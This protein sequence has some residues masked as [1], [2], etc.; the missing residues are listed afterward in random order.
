M[1]TFVKAAV[2]MQLA[3]D[4]V[5]RPHLVPPGGT[6]KWHLWTEVNVTAC[7]A[8]MKS[9]KTQNLCG[10]IVL[11]NRFFDMIRHMV[12]CIFQLQSDS[13]G[14]QKVAGT[15]VMTDLANGKQQIWLCDR[16]CTEYQSVRQQC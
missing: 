14:L 3:N 7:T 5:Q 2:H 4:P 12:P 13:A 8:I 9:L 11:S 1:Y 10:T 16:S 6:A 15:T